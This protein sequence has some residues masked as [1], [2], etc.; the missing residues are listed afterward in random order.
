MLLVAGLLGIAV[1]V[2][3]LLDATSPAY[4]GTPVLVAGIGR[5]TLR[6]RPRRVAGTAHPVPAAAVGGGGVFGGRRG[7][8]RGRGRARHRLTSVLY[9]TANPLVWPTLA[10]LPVLGL[11]VAALPAVMAPAPRMVTA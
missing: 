8:R 5:R 6:I 4:L 7:C 1:G 2:Y 3:A 10:V 11:L 9:P